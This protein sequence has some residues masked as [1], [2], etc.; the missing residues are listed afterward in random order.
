MNSKAGIQTNKAKLVLLLRDKEWL[1]A[2]SQV[3][4]AGPSWP[5][6]IGG[7]VLGSCWVRYR[8]IAYGGIHRSFLIRI[9]QHF[10]SYL[11]P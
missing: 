2:K 8:L 7:Q 1:Q 9:M 3:S 5:L 10:G 6:F 4:L 11:G